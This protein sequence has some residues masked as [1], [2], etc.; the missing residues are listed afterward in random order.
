MKE[1][2]YQPNLPLLLL[3]LS[4]F[5][6]LF[7]LGLLLALSPE[8]FLSDAKARRMVIAPFVPIV[9]WVTAGLVLY[10]IIRLLQ[11]LRFCF[12]FP[13]YISIT[14]N[15]LIV[16]KNISSGK[17][18]TLPIRSIQSVE[19][20]KHRGKSVLK[21]CHPN[22][23]VIIPELAFEDSFSFDEFVVAL[24][25]S[26]SSSKK[27]GVE[28]PRKPKKAGETTLFERIK[29]PDTNYIRRTFSDSLHGS[30][31]IDGELIGNDIKV[32]WSDEN[33][34]VRCMGRE[35][36]ISSLKPEALTVHGTEDFSKILSYNVSGTSLG[37]SVHGPLG[38]PGDGEFNVWV[39]I[40]FS[41][42][43]LFTDSGLDLQIFAK[44]L[45]GKPIRHVPKGDL[46]PH[47]ATIS[48]RIPEE[49]LQAFLRYDDKRY[50]VFK[51]SLTAASQ[52]PSD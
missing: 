40:E 39:I 30:F 28:F 42:K 32:Y 14:R 17:I 35:L 36:S 19:S 9:G 38:H 51:Q 4:I 6:V 27:A 15:D 45:D 44:T 1:F 24:R 11:A 46:P 31:M 26:I 29:S 3:A 10:Q 25:K 21:V 37:L 49:K 2:K 20:L 52:E 7:L 8:T 41:I 50:F 23:K 48:L 47:E 22:G 13:R 43:S 12:G 34:S 33:F 18:L 16:P 5:S